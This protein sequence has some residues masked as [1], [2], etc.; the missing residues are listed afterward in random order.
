MG[1]MAEIKIKLI[2]IAKNEAA[3]LPQWVFHHFRLGVDSIDVYINGSSDNSFEISRKINSFDP[4][5]KFYDADHRLKKCALKGKNF[6]KHIY[7]R[8]FKKCK[9][10]GSFSHLLILDLDEYLMP[11]KLE[12]NLKDLIRSSGETSV[13]AFPWCLD[14]PNSSEVKPFQRFICPII[15]LTP[16]RIVKSIGRISNIKKVLPHGFILSSKSIESSI[17]ANRILSIGIEINQN[18]SKI[19]GSHLGQKLLKTFKNRISESWFTLHRVNKSEAEYLA[20]LL[21]GRPSKVAKKDFNLLLK[22]NRKGFKIFDPKTMHQKIYNSSSVDTYNSDYDKFLQHLNIKTELEKSQNFILMQLDQLDNLIKENPN[23]I[24]T[25]AK[26][27][28]GTRYSP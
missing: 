15:N 13:V 4:R 7:N 14:A 8:A 27:F 11:D 26:Q 20:S 12:N 28:A 22:N 2:A 19:H 1:S 21:K 3:N 24:N 10:E 9:R 18:N 17:T 23:I 16:H 6:Q 25:F 5:F